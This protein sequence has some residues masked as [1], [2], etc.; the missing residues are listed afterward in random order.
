MKHMYYRKYS[1]LARALLL[2][3]LMNM[4]VF[5]LF[6]SGC[7]NM[8]QFQDVLPSSEFSVLQV[9]NVDLDLYVYAKQR[10][11]TT[12][13]ADLINMSEDVKVESLAMWGVPQENGFVLGLG[14]TF[15]SSETASSIF[16]QISEDENLW[17]F[18]RAN[19]LYIVKGSG[20]EADVLKSA[21]AN[22]DFVEYDDK[23]LLEAAD[24][25][26]Q[27]VRA[28]LIAFVL[29]NPSPE[30]INFIGESVKIEDI[31]QINENLRLANLKVFIGGLYSPDSINIARAAE[32]VK[33][34]GDLADLNLGLLVAI[35]SGLPGI[36]IE[37]NMKNMLSQQ[38]FTPVRI[39]EF[40]LYKGFWSTP[41]F[42]AIPVYARIESNYIFISISGQESY[43]ETLITSIYK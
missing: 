26:P 22:N 8:E 31:E 21:I 36:L 25:L 28:K 35:R 18:T 13:P 33:S 32:I 19:N 6:S 27:T 34:G 38:G 29:A 11:L 16:N 4:I 14:L 24:L 37:T 9:P 23:Q 39:G 20:V 3:I 5:T 42:N 43:A 10:A 15:D 30:L 1:K 41:S 12:V 7:Q 2:V 40:D 17:R